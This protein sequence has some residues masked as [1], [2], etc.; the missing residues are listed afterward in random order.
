M[1]VANP[2][3]EQLIGQRYSSITLQYMG[4]ETWLFTEKVGNV[5]PSSP[6]NN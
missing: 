3:V 2:T 4:G 1:Y 5:F 6:S